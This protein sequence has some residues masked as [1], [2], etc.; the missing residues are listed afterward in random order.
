MSPIGAKKKFPVLLDER[1]RAFAEISISAGTRGL[2]VLL[3]PQALAQVTNATW[4][5][6]G[7]VE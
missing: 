3:H 6:I 7:R 5:Q 4:A 2:Q 1:A